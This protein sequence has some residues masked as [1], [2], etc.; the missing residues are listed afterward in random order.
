MSRALNDRGSGDRGHF[1]DIACVPT[2]T[3]K[4]ELDA[5]YAAGTQIEGKFVALSFAVNYEVD[6]P[7]AGVQAN[8]DIKAIQEDIVN[9]TYR[10]TCRIWNFADDNGNIYPALNIVNKPYEGTLALQ[11]SCEVYATAT[12]YTFGD[13]DTD[14]FRNAVIGLDLPASGYADVIQG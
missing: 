5:F 1:L 2:S 14:G 9:S 3:M 7:A 4:T 12:Y 6:S 10:I 8:G 13:G 11:N